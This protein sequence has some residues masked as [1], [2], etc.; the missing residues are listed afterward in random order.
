[1]GDEDHIERIP[2]KTLQEKKPE[3]L[4]EIIVSFSSIQYDSLEHWGDPINPD[5]DLA[6]VAEFWMLLNPDSLLILAVPYVDY[7]LHKVGTMQRN[8]NRQ[9]SQE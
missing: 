5:D 6:A 7:L 4:F 3:D 9:H 1:M 8:M 2:M